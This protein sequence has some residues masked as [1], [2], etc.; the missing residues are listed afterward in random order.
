MNLTMM[1]AM[2]KAD[3][4]GIS[5]DEALKL[6]MKQFDLM[7]NAIKDDAE[8]NWAMTGNF[9]DENYQLNLQICKEF[10]EMMLN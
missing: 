8:K 5:Q 10:S 2:L 3:I 7:F 9:A 1:A 4:A 6:N